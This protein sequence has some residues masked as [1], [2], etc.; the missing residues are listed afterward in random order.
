VTVEE[1]GP[2]LLVR[3]E[4]EEKRNAIDVETAVGI[5]ADGRHAWLRIRPEKFVSWDFRKSPALRGASPTA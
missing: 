2:I 3:I 5:D 4:R 1:R